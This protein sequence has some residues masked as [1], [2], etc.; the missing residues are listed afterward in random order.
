MT[1]THCT[2][3]FVLLLAFAAGCG[4]PPTP[5]APTPN[6]TQ[7]SSPTPTSAP[8][9]PATPAS[10]EPTS[11][12][13]PAAPE[14][15]AAATPS[16]PTT[17]QGRILGKPFKAVAACAVRGAEPGKVLLEIYDVKDFDVQKQCMMLPPTP[18]ARKIGFSLEWKK[19]TK[20]D[21]ASLGGTDGYVM[22]VGPKKKF[23]RKV[24]NKDFKPKGEI[25]ILKAPTASGSVGRIELSLTNGKDKLAGEVDVFVKNDL[26]K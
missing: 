11:K 13:T 5:A 4:T 12:A 23:S 15:A 6:A 16:A 8:E 21:L 25:E 7:A 10:A 20:V 2:S 26:D 22:Q 9:V 24:I 3:F 19:G 17:L 18:G 1:A 14:T